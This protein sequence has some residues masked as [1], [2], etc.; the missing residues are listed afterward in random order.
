MIKVYRKIERTNQYLFS[1]LQRISEEI[2]EKDSIS[3]ETKLNLAGLF[4]IKKPEI[5]LKIYKMLEKENSNDVNLWIDLASFYYT[6]KEYY[7]AIDII[8]KKIEK[9]YRDYMIYYL[10]GDLYERTK[11][12]EKAYE[13]YKEAL[14]NWPFIENPISSVQKRE[15]RLGKILIKKIK[16]LEDILSHS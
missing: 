12:Y 13:A 9:K 16:M 6:K 8:E 1:L 2:I 11:N 10:L 15:N 5:A 3:Y 14:K 4:G 7:K